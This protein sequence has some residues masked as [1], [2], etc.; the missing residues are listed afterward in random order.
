ME[1]FSNKEKEDINYVERDEKYFS[2]YLLYKELDSMKN[3]IEEK[4]FKLEER[5]I[6]KVFSSG[7]LEFVH[8]FSN[9]WTY[10]PFHAFIALKFG[11]FQII[12]YLFRYLRIKCGPEGKDTEY[13]NACLEALIYLCEDNDVSSKEMTSNSLSKKEE[14]KRD[15]NESFLEYIS[16][17]R[18]ENIGYVPNVMDWIALHGDLNSLK[19]FSDIQGLVCTY[20]GTD[21]AARN[22]HHDVVKYL[23]EVHNIR[24]T[25]FGKEWSVI[26]GHLEVVKYLYEEEWLEFSS[27][28][29]DWAAKNGHLDIL[30]YLYEV[31]NVKCTSYGADLAAEKGHLDVLKYLLQEQKIKCTFSGLNWAKRERDPNFIK[32]LH[33]IRKMRFR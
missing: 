30:K 26:N 3:L 33:E 29:A 27:E 12:E 4:K 17:L 22:G 10:T 13:R 5:H 16:Y 6:Q 25:S 21:W 14:K 9:F 8:Y 20:Y 31:Q 7:H 15:E 11:H 19:Y 32:I 2:I 28:D 1:I 24:C 23:Y 18:K